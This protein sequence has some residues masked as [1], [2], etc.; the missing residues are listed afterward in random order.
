MIDFWVAIHIEQAITFPVQIC[1]FGD[2]IALNVFVR[3][4]ILNFKLEGVILQ[5]LAGF[6]K[7]GERWKYS[8]KVIVFEAL[9]DAA[10]IDDPVAPF[11]PGIAPPGRAT[12][13]PIIEL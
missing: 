4:H 7:G 6:R 8:I 5:T 2:D 1:K 12:A 10:G 11:E 13:V 3:T 9:F